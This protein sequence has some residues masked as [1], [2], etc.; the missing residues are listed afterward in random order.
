MHYLLSHAR[1]PGRP[2]RG[3]RVDEDVRL[4]RPG[5]TATPSCASSSRTRR[6]GGAARSRA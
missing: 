2:A 5:L 3:M 1:R 6:S 4:N